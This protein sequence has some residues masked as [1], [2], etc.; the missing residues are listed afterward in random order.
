M[1]LE[2]A[3]KYEGTI[4]IPMTVTDRGIWNKLTGSF[5]KDSFKPF[6]LSASKETLLKRLPLALTTK[7]HGE[8]SRLTAVSPPLRILSSDTQS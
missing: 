7:I 3:A 4:I 2:I 5:D 8:R 6:I 1:L